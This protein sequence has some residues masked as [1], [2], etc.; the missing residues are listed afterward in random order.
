MK[1]NDFVNQLIK[2]ATEASTTYL[3][4]GFGC[5]LGLDWYNKDY[6]WNKEHAEQLE[7]KYNTNPITFGYDCVCLEK[8]VLW[9]GTN[10]PNLENGGAKYKSNGVGDITVKA[11]SETCA[12][13]TDKNWENIEAGEL[14]FLKDFGHTGVY[15]GNGLVVESTPAWKCGVQLTALANLGSVAGYPSRRWDLHGHTSFVEYDFSWEKVYKDLSARFG[16]L[17]AELS[18]VE[19]ENKKLHGE[20]ETLQ[21]AILAQNTALS[22]AEANFKQAELSI[23]AK[24]KNIEELTEKLQKLQQSHWESDATADK[25][26]AQLQADLAEQEAKHQ[27]EA[28]SYQQEIDRL[29]ERLKEADEKIEALQ[30]TNGDVNGDGKVTISDVIAVV[31]FWMRGDRK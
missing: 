16:A 30:K 10:N 7:K 18:K 12:D 15:V 11:M 13:L 26:I 23:K 5:R 3:M 8:S 14:V 25:Q 1:V 24:D 28:Q 20:I 4:G 9:G 6:T 31:G 2:T 29:T 21:N 19:A 27:R 17:E 22:K